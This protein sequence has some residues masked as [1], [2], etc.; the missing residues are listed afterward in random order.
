MVHLLNLNAVTMA[1]GAGHTI[2]SPA[3][4]KRKTA[5]LQICRAL[6]CGQIKKV[7]QQNDRIANTTAFRM[8]RSLR[9][10]KV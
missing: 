8:K 5:P 3:A 6:K 9:K 10:R 7:L 4:E 1:Q 2:M